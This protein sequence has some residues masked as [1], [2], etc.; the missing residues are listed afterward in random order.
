M[1]PGRPDSIIH[2]L[3]ERKVYWFASP[4][5]ISSEKEHFWVCLKIGDGIILL[6][7]CTSKGEKRIQFIEQNDISP[8]TLVRIENDGTNYFTKDTYVDC[9]SIHTFSFEEFQKKYDSGFL[10][11][12]GEIGVEHFEQILIGIH[13]SDLLSDAQKAEL[14]TPDDW[15]DSQ[16]Y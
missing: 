4:D 3:Q 5:R 12:K 13:S 10:K 8:K 7:C 9:N 14:P 15:L 16:G 2:S 6:S 1:I 11:S